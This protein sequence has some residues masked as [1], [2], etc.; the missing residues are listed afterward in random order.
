MVISDKRRWLEITAVFAT[1]LLKHVFMDWLE[2]RAFYIAAAS[3]FWS[4]Y[5]YSRY[6]QNKDILQYWGFRK[7][8][9]NQTFLFLLPFALLTVAIIVWYGIFQHTILNWYFFPVLII[10]PVWGII[11]Q[12]MIVTL[13]AGNL[14]SITTIKLSKIQIFLLTSVVFAWVHYPS[15]PL[16]IFTFFMELLF[17]F[18]FFK[19]KNLW[20]LGLFHGWIASFLLFIVLDRDLWIELW[21]V[22]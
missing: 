12:F 17:L 13:V 9:F 5:I 19:W 3:L 20:P 10:Y 15:L 21:S 18:A 4:V 11:Q 2:F 22:F 1:G 14:H 8:H 6:Q 16:M 7:D